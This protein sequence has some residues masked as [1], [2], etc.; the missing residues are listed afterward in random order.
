[1]R[2]ILVISGEKLY[3]YNFKFEG[4]STA[5]LVGIV[6]VTYVKIYQNSIFSYIGEQFI[7]I[8][9]TL[10]CNCKVDPILLKQKSD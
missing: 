7:K 4:F 10:F 5:S 3:F 1:L 8:S 6:I 2:G 9:S